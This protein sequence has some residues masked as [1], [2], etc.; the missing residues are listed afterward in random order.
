VTESDVERLL[1]ALH[2]EGVQFV[3]IEGLAA[4]LQGSAYVTADLDLCYSRK[5]ENPQKLARALTAFHPSLRAVTE[6]VPFSLDASALASGMNFTLATDAGD[7]D[8]LGEVTGM[9]DYQKVVT[10]AEEM[11]IFG[12]TCKVLTV[13]GLIKAKQAVARAKDLRLLP[14]LEALLELQKAEKKK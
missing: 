10:F 3:I 4:V 14:E 8:I 6:P 13:E 9:G 2:Q 7:L 12:I 5:K 11:E 1:K